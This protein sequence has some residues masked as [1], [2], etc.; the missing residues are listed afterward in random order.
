MPA[1]RIVFHGANAKGFAELLDQPAEF[2]R[3]SDE[4]A[5]EAERRAYASAEVLIG[6]K[7]NKSF[8]YP[9]NL[10]L[11]HLPGAGFDKVDFAAL[12]P[13]AML[14]NCFS[15]EPAIAEYVIAALL[16]FEI[17]FVDAD[18]RLRQGDW[19]YRAAS[20]DHT[21]GELG[22]RTIGILGFGH[23]GKAVAA[24]AKAFGMKVH[25]ANRS[26]V[27]PSALI[28]RV[29]RVEEL[30]AFWAS[31]DCFLISVPLTPETRGIVG[32]AAF[33]AMPRHA[34]LVNVA[35]GPAVD[36]QALYTALKSGRIRGA[37]VDTWY[38][39]PSA[40]APLTQPSR[41]PFHELSNIIMTPHMSGWTMGTIRRRQRTIADNINRLSRGEACVNLLRAPQGTAGTR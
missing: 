37:I 19:T 2:I 30:A 10:K 33:N 40:A 12:P 39:Y 9:E 31:A 35:R 25:V 32:E 13:Q 11:M 36:E 3:V 16:L 6:Y 27:A 26:P 18:R 23:I 38:Q 41:L 22:E 17:P 28:D 34:V 29:F 21:H 14:C 15:H 20:L 8:P 5:E 24:R 4:L 7:F 1:M